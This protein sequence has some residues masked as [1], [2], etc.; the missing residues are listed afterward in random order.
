MPY[1][2]YYVV[3][4]QTKKIEPAKTTNSSVYFTGEKKGT[5]DMMIE[6][7]GYNHEKEAE[8]I[9]AALKNAGLENHYCLIRIETKSNL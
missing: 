8:K 9:Y 3:N 4:S 7:F 5:I 2:N 6:V 1:T